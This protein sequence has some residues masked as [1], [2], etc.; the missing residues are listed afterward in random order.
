[1]E[2][3]EMGIGSKKQKIGSIQFCEMIFTLLI[4]N[5]VDTVSIAYLRMFSVKIVAAHFPPEI[6][7]SIENSLL[8]FSGFDDAF[9]I[10]S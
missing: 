1:M 10:A 7:M 9:Q 8:F 6:F 4:T 3:N 5:Q 2:E